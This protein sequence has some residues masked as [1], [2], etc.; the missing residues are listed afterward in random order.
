MDT[1]LASAHQVRIKMR[2]KC[3]QSARHTHQ[4]KCARYPCPSQLPV[5]D[6]RPATAGHHSPI[7]GHVTK[8]HGKA[9]VPNWGYSLMK[10]LREDQSDLLGVWTCLGGQVQNPAIEA[11]EH[12][13][14][15]MGYVESNS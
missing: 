5:T 7:T 14:T 2:T 12:L 10:L 13:L 3:P 1:P 4:M 9:G 15:V 6:H 11:D 8:N